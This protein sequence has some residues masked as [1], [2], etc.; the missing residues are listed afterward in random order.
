LHDG[1][2]AELTTVT[3][4][5]ARPVFNESLTEMTRRVERGRARLG[6]DQAPTGA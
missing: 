2:V 5:G 3:P 4:T 1:V 6:A